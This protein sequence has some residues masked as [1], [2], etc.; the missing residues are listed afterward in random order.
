MNNINGFSSIG[1]IP[2]AST[3]GVADPAER[4]NKLD[5]DGSGRLDTTELSDLATSLSKI[6]GKTLEISSLIESYDADNDGEM[7]QNETGAMIGQTLGLPPNDG[8]G[9]F[10][11]M[12]DTSLNTAT[13]DQISE[14]I[15]MLQGILGTTPPPPEERFATFDSDGDG[16]LDENEMQA[17]ADDLAAVTGETIDTAEALNTYDTDSDGQLSAEEIEAMLDER[18]NESGAPPPPP[19]SAEVV[20]NQ[21]QA[22]NAYRENS[23]ED[24]LETLRRLLLQFA[25]LQSASGS[26]T[27]TSR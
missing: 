15:E 21:L 11:L 20:S 27:S 16:R 26:S 7:N 9:A 17:L 25:E 23:G 24:Q 10:P 13:G 19:A 3:K 14:L 22:V 5:A 6:I 18:M 2:S 1:S 8:T 4:F 12:S